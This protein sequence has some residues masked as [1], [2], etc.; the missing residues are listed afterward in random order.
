MIGQT[1]E[2]S[3]K[4]LSQGRK[5]N[6]ETVQLMQR[7]AHERAG[8]P[9]VRSLALSITSRLPSN[10]YADEAKAIGKFVQENVRYIRDAIGYEQVQ[11]PL[12]MIEHI[13][14]SRAQGDCDDMAILTATLLLSIG[15]TPFYRLVRY[16]SI[17][18]PYNHIYVVDYEKNGR[19]PKQRIVIDPIIKD[20]VIGYEVPHKNG[21]E[22][23][24]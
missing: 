21:K 8:H 16:K 15:H 10:A 11:D 24:A 7:V 2:V 4:T 6:L 12:M 17:W 5:G 18:G 3:S 1:P 23:L 9:V 22:I 13:M 19:N 20:E 14:E